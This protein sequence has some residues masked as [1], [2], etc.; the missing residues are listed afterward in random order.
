MDSLLSVK[1]LKTHFYSGGRI[2]RA[3]DGVSFDI[4]EEFHPTIDVTT[5]VSMEMEPDQDPATLID[6]HHTLDLTEVVRQDLW[7]NLPTS[8]ACQ[9]DCKGLCSHCGQNL[10]QGSCGC[11][12]QIADVRWAALLVDMSP[13]EE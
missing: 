4:E 12:T 13:Q 7:L 11:K 10:N 3:L 2:I 5:G 6:E 8:P 1:N 9:P